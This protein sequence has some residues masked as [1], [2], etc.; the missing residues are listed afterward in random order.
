MI[1]NGETS[2]V[3]LQPETRLGRFVLS[4][5][6]LSPASLSCALVLCLA[7][8]WALA[9]QQQDSTPINAPREQVTQN[10]T[11]ARPVALT[12]AS[13][14]GEPQS[15]VS[16][17]HEIRTMLRYGVTSSALKSLHQLEQQ[18]QPGEW[19]YGRVCWYIALCHYLDGDQQQA[20][21]W[22]EL[23]KLSGIPELAGEAAEFW[24]QHEAWQQPL[25]TRAF[26][27]YVSASSSDGSIH[28]VSMVSNETDNA[29]TAKQIVGEIRRTQTQLEKAAE[30][31]A[32]LEEI[33]LATWELLLGEYTAFHD[34]LSLW[35]TSVDSFV[36]GKNRLAEI[37][38][39][40]Q[41]SPE[42]EDTISQHPE[43]AI[44]LDSARARLV[45]IQDKEIASRDKEVARLQQLRN[46]ARNYRSLC[47]AML[48]WQMYQ[49]LLD[50]GKSAASA[51]QALVQ[52]KRVFDEVDSQRDFHLFDDEPAVDGDSEFNV[53]ELA[54]AP[55][56]NSSLSL[57]KALQG[58]TY[59]QAMGD[60]QQPQ[61]ELLEKARVWAT[62][63]L[64]AD[65]NVAELPAGS[66]PQNLIAKLVM[67]LVE[68]KQGTDAAFSPTASKRQQAA[69]HFDKA[70]SELTEL[71]TLIQGDAYDD[72]PQLPAAVQAKLRELK[73][74]QY[75]RSEAAKYLRLGQTTTA[76]ELLISATKIHRD[77]ATALQALEV[78]LRFG[79]P[80][81]QMLQ[82]WKQYVA[83]GIFSADDPITRL[84]YAKL[85]NSQAGHALAD[86]DL[87]NREPL[88]GEL[89]EVAKQLTA[90]TDDANLDADLRSSLKANFA[91][92][93]A[94]RWALE[95]T[96]AGASLAESEIEAAY[97]HA[98]DAE[99]YLQK[100]LQD[101]PGEPHDL[102]TQ[103]L[104]EAL[105]A[106]RLAAGHLAALYL[107]DWRDESQIF[108]TAAAA[109][110]AKLSGTSPLL[111][112]VGEPLLRQF[113]DESDGGHL[114][115]ANQERQRRQM[116]TRCLEAMFTSRFGKPAEGAQ[117]MEQAVR[118]GVGTAG[119]S[120][121]LRASDLSAS[122]DGFD[123]KVSLPDTLRAFSVL[124]DIEAGQF[125][126][127]LTKAVAVASKDRVRVDAPESLTTQ[128][129]QTCIQGIES[130]LIAFT[131]AKALEAFL[132]ALPPTQEIERRQWLSQ[133]ALAAY[134]KG[135]QMLDAQRLAVRY[136]HLISLIDEAIQNLRDSDGYQQQAVELLA[137]QKV[138]AALAVAL[139]GLA[140][141]P[142]N[143]ALWNTYF[144]C[145]IR[146]ADQ[147]GEGAMAELRGLVQ[148]FDEAQQ[149]DLLDA[150]SAASGT[151]Q[152]FELLGDLKHAEQ[153]Y[154]L[155][156][157]LSST[158]AQRIAAVSNAERLRVVLAGLAAGV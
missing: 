7:L 49:T 27:T 16:L 111:P 88:L 60:Q 17:E 3:F 90:W 64:E 109:E 55:M 142:D 39:K 98:R 86:A 24:S 21:K 155:A 38:A 131:Y 61:P 42:L 91:L 139:D 133:Q 23:A 52:L 99:F 8:C 81:Q 20:A 148:E 9:V 78:G 123:A 89:R 44:R 80:P 120:T 96:A 34:S 6:S 76:R 116:V 118:M 102:T 124:A 28:L 66:D 22:S 35:T 144:Q 11:E 105:I 51:S 152:V 128:Q 122:A 117:Q 103:A 119:Q 33:R 72:S 62:A 141:H 65:K 104:R 87:Q 93:M 136:P 138:P 31:E 143:K 140:R 40:I 43:I 84:T 10:A 92:C 69:Q 67:G 97:R 47:E 151:A 127:A 58:L 56:S 4:R 79:L 54:P 50:P 149:L 129:S 15:A 59:L 150:F 106:S 13:P 157:Q 5:A 82:E 132:S 114:K 112:L 115:L 57:M 147:A 156:E 137:S 53:V 125:S 14:A 63:A 2:N 75:A 41:L 134:Q 154:R 29:Q 126:G 153:R 113:F 1:L 101:S 158:A 146:Q 30:E 85:V 68:A 94:Y 108:F 26:Q 70:R 19:S 74:V 83:L 77:S 18:E 71:S 130:P 121:N 25:Q 48:D 46:I 37:E 12:A 107:D 95:S 36:S 45:A 100:K 32:I 73:D 145:R 135:K 110:A